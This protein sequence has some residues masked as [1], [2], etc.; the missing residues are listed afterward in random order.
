[1]PVKKEEIVISLMKDYAPKR[2]KISNANNG[3]AY[4]ACLV[5]DKR[6]CL[7]QRWNK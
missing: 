5:L 3:R 2:G 4:M 6:Y 7:L 1:M